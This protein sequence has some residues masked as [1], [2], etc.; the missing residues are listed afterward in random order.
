VLQQQPVKVPDYSLTKEK[1]SFP[2]EEQYKNR[3][4]KGLEEVGCVEV[5]RKE[6]TCDFSVLIPS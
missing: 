4:V 3:G 5:S 6:S 1:E 2:E